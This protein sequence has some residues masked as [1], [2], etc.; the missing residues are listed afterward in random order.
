MIGMRDTL[1][2]YHDCWWGLQLV[3]KCLKFFV[4]ILVLNAMDGGLIGF[5]SYSDLS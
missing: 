1:F 5:V 3:I 4:V 2:A